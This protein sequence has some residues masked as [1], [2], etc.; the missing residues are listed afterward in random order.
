MSDSPVRGPENVPDEPVHALETATI[1]RLPV[2]VVLPGP[3]GEDEL[4]Y[5]SF[6][7]A[8]PPA[9]SSARA[10]RI[11]VAFAGLRSR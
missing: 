10:S 8:P 11:R 5:M 9:A 4:H 3:P 7:T 6:R 1:G 2:Q